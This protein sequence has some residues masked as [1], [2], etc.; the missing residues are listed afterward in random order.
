M[1]NVSKGNMTI[2]KIL[3]ICVL[4]VIT[5][6]CGSKAESYVDAVR[7]GYR[8]DAPG[9]TYGDAFDQYFK[10]DSWDEYETEHGI[11]VE[12]NGQGEYKGEPA[13]V[14]VK[15]LIRNESFKQFDIV[16]DEKG[17][18]SCVYLSINGKCL[19]NQAAEKFITHVLDSFKPGVYM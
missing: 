3:L 15:F 4:F 6:G 9:V 7:G 16:G 18:F 12:F 1:C 8:V 11:I 17:T 13:K 19:N 14:K 10:K 5:A 2:Y